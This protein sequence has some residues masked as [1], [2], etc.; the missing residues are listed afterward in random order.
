MK[1]RTR[2]L[3]LVLGVWIPAAAGFGFLA[4]NTYQREV[5]A[6]HASVRDA[7]NALSSLLEREL[8]ARAVAARTLA[9]STLLA[10]R[11]WSGFH[12]EATAA[13]RATSSWAF[14]VDRERQVLNTRLPAERQSLVRTS[15]APLF[16]DQEA[17]VVF[18]VK[19][20]LLGRPVIGVFAAESR[21]VPPAYNVGVALEPTVVQAIVE[22][23]PLPSGSLA[24]VVDGE[25]RII[26]RNR[27]PQKYIGVQATD[28]MR[29]RLLRREAGFLRSVT[30]DG[31]ASLSY[32]SAPSRHDWSV[33]IALPAA[34]LDKAAA[35]I[36][37]QAVSAAGALLLIGLAVALVAER[38]ISAPILAL[39][40]AAAELGRQSVPAA[41]STGVA[42][43]DEVSAALH[44]AGLRAHDATHEL[45]R[46][47]ATAV[48]E[49]RDTQARL[50][51]AQKHEAIGRL[52]GGIAH[53]FNNLLQTITTALHV[54]QRSD[55]DGSQARVLEAALRACTKATELVR[56]MLTFGRSQPLSPQ[57]LE[58]AD[59]IAKS[60]EL[61]ARALGRLRL[62]ATVA[63]GVPALFVDPTQLELAVLNLVFNA[64]DAMPAGGTVRIVARDAA[65]EETAPLGGG[66]FV[67][68]EVIDDGPGMDAATRA[69]AFEPYFTT[70]PVGAGSGL[71]LSQVL[72]FARQS[73][74]DARIDSEPGRG[75]RV[76]MLLPAAD[77]AALGTPG[78]DRE[79]AP[80]P[81][82]RAA[83]ARPLRV[84]MVEDD[85]LVATV[86]I[87]AL[88]KAGHRVTACNSSDDARR[89]L[90]RGATFDVLFTDV[91]MAGAM[92]G[93]ELAQWCA[94]H[95]PSLP[96]LVA[97]GYMAQQIDGRF[98]VLRKPYTVDA[99]LLALARL[100]AAPGTAG[101]TPAA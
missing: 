8:D 6:A 82:A 62:D 79:R 36:T 57:V 10:Q 43:A 13:L 94:E 54:L 26:A 56:Q 65:A 89:L 67:A 25:Q 72:G 24:S 21:T 85:P 1:I 20:P 19:G 31:V 80:A 84:L 33:V 96:V 63:P 18:N 69:N 17:H 92:N 42:E 55:P 23:L 53:D 95:R 7:G 68:V 2:L 100:V 86:L 41:L 77:V 12:A 51:D 40:G 101:S 38:R 50:L 44:E 76:V 59:F 99:L 14:V 4:W 49:T 98:D 46:R 90:E 66:R 71:G 64:R 61:T 39:R 45:E 93:A 22:Q 37:L 81:A 48:Q 58:V 15:A 73:G 5:E 34:A 75:T 78:V 74:G 83:D 52:T 47:V 87:P 60:E 11:D 16:T 28:P 97:T 9:A 35:R 30:L 88:E 27:E 70:K 32:I 91:V 3:L 29:E